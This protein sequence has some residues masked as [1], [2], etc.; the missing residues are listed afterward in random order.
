MFGKAQNLQFQCLEK[1]KLRIPLFG[2]NQNS[3]FQCL[4]KPKFR[5]PIFEI[6]KI[7]N[8]SVWKSQNLLFQCLEKPMIKNCNVWNS[9]NS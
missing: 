2:K 3:L 1:P 8:F 9:E 5:I 7:P 6:A 4:E